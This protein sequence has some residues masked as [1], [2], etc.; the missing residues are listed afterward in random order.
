MKC[1]YGKGSHSPSTKYREM[2]ELPPNEYS[3]ETD[4]NKLQHLFDNLQDDILDEY[5]K[6]TISK[7]EMKNIL[8]WLN[9]MRG[10]MKKQLE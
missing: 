6:K 2:T 3:K 1:Y 5:N 9:Q 7:K 10:R 4:I 8:N